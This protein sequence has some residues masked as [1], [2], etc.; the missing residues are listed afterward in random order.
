M[1]PGDTGSANRPPWKTDAGTACHEFQEAERSR[2]KC[3]GLVGNRNVRH[4]DWWRKVR[5][6]Y[7]TRLTPGA[8]VLRHSLQQHRLDDEAACLRSRQRGVHLRGQRCGRVRGTS[9]ALK[10]GDLRGLA[11]A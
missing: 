8:T 2:C 1:L 6:L 4:E 10:Y 7:A 3:A 9:D 5:T 11:Q